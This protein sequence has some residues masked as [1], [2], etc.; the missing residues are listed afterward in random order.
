MFVCDL[1][2]GGDFGLAANLGGYEL[3]LHSFSRRDLH[4]LRSSHSLPTGD[5]SSG[6][7]D[8]RYL[9]LCARGSSVFLWKD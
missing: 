8:S 4:D 5:C 3:Q 1:S 6:A 9:P 7:P 2:F